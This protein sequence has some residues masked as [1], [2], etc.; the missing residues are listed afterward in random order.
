M[1][2]GS[3]SPNLSLPAPRKTVALRGRV[4]IDPE[5]NAKKKWGNEVKPTLVSQNLA[6]SDRKDPLS[7][8]SKLDQV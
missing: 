6:F 5:I 2:V 7:G 4:G 1:T 8:G 3:T